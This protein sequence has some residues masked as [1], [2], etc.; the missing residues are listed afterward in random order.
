MN[1]IRKWKRWMAVGCSHGNHADKTA[2]RT[3]LKFKSAYK[4]DRTL[5]LGEWSDMAALRSGAHG[6]KDEAADIDYDLQAGLNFVRDL[7]PET[8]FDGNHED[9]LNQMTNHP[10]AIVA[11][12][13]GKIVGEV[14]DFCARYKVERVPYGIQTGWRPLGNFLFGHG[15][16]FDMAAIRWH[17]L[18]VG[19]CVI[20]HL[21]RTG[22]ERA[23][24]L[25]G[26]TGYCLGCLADI[27][28]LTYA[29]T[30][31]NTLRWNLGFAYGE[32]CDTACTVNIVARADNGDWRLPS[33]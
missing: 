24:R 20:A 11:Y 15:Y 17:A 13:A 10:K 21:H 33:V 3:V 6:S 8:L 31:K 32:Y 16:M 26:A 25:G 30:K 27:P 23:E 7:E 2:L 4:P 9:R 29:K 22:E 28:A 1:I 19:N 5:H 12:C 14:N 18:T